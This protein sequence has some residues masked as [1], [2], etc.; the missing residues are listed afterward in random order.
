MSIDIRPATI[1][2]AAA[3]QRIY[4]PIVADTA[5]SFEEVPPTVEQMAE[6]IAS[7]LKTHPYLVAATGGDVCG[8]VY[9][10]EHAA[11]SAY[12]YSVT[13]TVYI[14][15]EARGNGVGRALYAELFQD[16]VRRR[17]AACRHH[18]AKPG[19]RSACTRRSA[20]NRSASTA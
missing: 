15:A 9:A 14:A 18:A 16:L 6:R 11:R 20:S 13:T 4:A 1:E 17:F 5:I 19:K 2:D 7:I 12:R 8:F 10:A 3:I